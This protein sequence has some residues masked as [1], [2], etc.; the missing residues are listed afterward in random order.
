MQLEVKHKFEE[1]PIY[2]SNKIDG[3]IGII[4]WG[5]NNV[6]CQILM[7]ILKE[8]IEHIGVKDM[9]DKLYKL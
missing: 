4:M 7:E 8:K 3:G 1:M 6:D 5:A 2:A 9:I